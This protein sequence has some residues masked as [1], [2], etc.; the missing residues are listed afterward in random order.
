[1]VNLNG[2]ARLTTFV[3]ATHLLA[4]IP[5]TDLTTAGSSSITVTNPAG[6]GTSEPKT[7]IVA[8][9]PTGTNDDLRQCDDRDERDR[10]SLPLPGDARHNNVY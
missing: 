2:N 1:M 3:D 5:A 8:Q 9:A 4:S 6:G 7:L 10:P